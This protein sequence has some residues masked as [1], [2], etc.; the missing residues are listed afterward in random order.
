MPR[1][2]YTGTELYT[3]GFYY[4]KD[5]GTFI[6][7]KN[8]I[9]LG[10]YSA[11]TG[12]NTVQGVVD[13]WKNNRF[14]ADYGK[15]PT[16]WGVFQITNNSIKIERWFG[17]NAGEPLPTATIKGKILNKTTLVVTESYFPPQHK[18]KSDTFYFYPLAVK[19]DS[20][21]LFVK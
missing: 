4:N 20:T 5:F 11:L 13:F 16:N 1:T 9:Y 14:L 15:D 19:P 12:V 6:L 2:D 8:G 7:Y 21:N 17:R 3:Q 18:V 10:G